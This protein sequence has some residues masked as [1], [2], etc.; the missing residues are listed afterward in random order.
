MIYTSFFDNLN[1]I[2]SDI[3]PISIA[4]GPPEW[5]EGLEYKKLA[6]KLSFF[7]VWEQTKDNEY[8]IDNYNK[9]I[10]DK[11][12][13]ESVINDIY[14]KLSDT[15]KNKLH[16]ENRTILDSK[17]VN[18]VLLCYEKPNEFCHRHLVRNWFNQHN[19]KVEEWRN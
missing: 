3:I 13:I 6:P 12:D 14:N 2:N 17:E 9:L 1:S 15:Y 11:L 7:K 18:I 16:K 19:I 4:G 8:Y 10:L 5:Y